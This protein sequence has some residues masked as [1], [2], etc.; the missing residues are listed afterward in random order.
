MVSDITKAAYLRACELELK[1][2]KPGNVSIYSPG[3]DM[4][5]EDFRL[6][7]EVSASHLCN[8]S[9]TLGERIFEAVRATREAV[10]CNTNLGIVLLA[11][12]LIL[13]FEDK[14]AHK[15]LH[16]AVTKILQNTTVEDA[17]LVYKAIRKANPGGLGTVDE[18]DVNSSPNMT[19]TDAMRLAD[20]RD[21][22][23][24]Q[25]TGSF[26]D[27]FH[28][29]IP[30]YDDGLSQWDNE[31]W[32]AVSVYIGLLNRIPDSH[33]ERKFGTEQ[34][35]WITEQMARLEASFS[36]TESPLT[37]LPDLWNIDREFKNRGI[38]PGTTADLTVACLLVDGLMKHDAK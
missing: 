21:S 23:A 5:V 9:L 29:A 16:E 10:G 2:F 18:G 26:F 19:L 31:E 15:T 14:G 37:V 1:A 7:A 17:E 12:P 25:Y 8:S 20:T 4:T 30:M 38:N 24:R 11:A 35:Q 32:A 6:S 13:A 22:I 27:I 3:H 34:T 33:V 36:E 28:L